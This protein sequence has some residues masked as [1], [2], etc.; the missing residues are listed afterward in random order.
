MPYWRLFYHIVWA[1]KNRLPLINPDWEE[2]LY[3]YLWGKAEGIG[4]F[5]HV[6]NGMPDHIHVAVSIPP[7]LAVSTVIG[8]FKGS[9]SHY[10]NHTIQT[11]NYFAWQAGY[12]VISCSE[13]QLDGVISYVRSQKQNHS[14]D[15]LW[16]DFETFSISP[17][18]A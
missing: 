2:D 14:K 9:S 15:A 18:G 8:R 3:S 16:K 12:G 1:T 10:I 6:I 7:K 5:P 13:R 4:C 11:G 17:R